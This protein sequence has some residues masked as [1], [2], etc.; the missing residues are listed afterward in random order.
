MRNSLLHIHTRSPSTRVSTRNLRIVLSRS[1]YRRSQRTTPIKPM[2]LAT[3]RNLLKPRTTRITTQGRLSSNPRS[4]DH[5]PPAPANANP[6]DEGLDRCFYALRTSLYLAQQDLTSPIVSTGTSEKSGR[7]TIAEEMRIHDT[8]SQNQKSHSRGVL[9]LNEG[10][11]RGSRQFCCFPSVSDNL[12]VF[13]S[14]AMP[15]PPA[16][17]P[18]PA[19]TL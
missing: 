10:P 7:I 12:R 13:G 15:T 19:N 17:G 3:D 9:S 2:P 14:T 16:N 11:R 18:Q 1:G 5:H 8:F 4:C 6:I